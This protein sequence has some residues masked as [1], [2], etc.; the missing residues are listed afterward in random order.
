MGADSG[1]QEN[2][3]KEIFGLRTAL[4]PFFVGAIMIFLCAA[5]ILLA[6]D[7]AVPALLAA[8]IPAAFVLAAYP[9]LS[10]Y[11]YIFTLF[12]HYYPLPGSTVLLL[13]L[14]T[15]LLLA[16]YAIDFLL[17]GNS[18]MKVPGIINYFL[19]LI[20]LMVF[21]AVFAYHPEYSIKPI[22]RVIFQI[23]IIIAIYNS[24]NSKD[25][26]YFLRFGFLLLLAHAAVNVATFVSTGGSYRVFGSAN[27]YFND[28]A[29]LFA[30]VGIAGYLWGK[31]SR[32]ALFFGFAT[33]VVLFG[34]IATQSRAPLVTAVWVGLVV[35]FVA[36]RKA[37]RQGNLP[38][39]RKARMILLGVAVMAAIIILFSDIFRDVGERFRTLAD[40]DT[41]TVWLRVSLWKAA[42]VA[43]LGDPL[44]GIG[45]GNYRY[46]DSI[47]P[48]LKFDP[49]RYYVTGYSSHNIFLHYLAETGLLGALAMVAIYLKNFRTA[50]KINRPAQPEGDPS[51]SY[52]LLGAGLTIFAALFYLNGWMWGHSAFLAPLF[53]ALTAKYYNSISNG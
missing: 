9:R 21:S 37:D 47:I 25:I 42:L 48:S 23:P 38:V 18:V 24:V 3:M 40:V 26:G 30:P 13:D 31:S 11:L 2:A 12:I 7:R 4:G 41:G 29:M 53:I 27:V 50:L 19:V 17:K 32:S 5:A 36:H 8:M 22:L 14:V 44:T 1:R 34:M 39:K 35:V 49:A 46:I 16:S 10:L 51:V 20:C 52:A 45:P 28:I 43:F 15:L 6:A 33:I